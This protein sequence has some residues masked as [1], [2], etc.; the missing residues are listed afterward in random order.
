[1][2]RRLHPQSNH[3][4]SILY[5][6]LDDWRRTEM[7]KIKANTAAGDERN[8]AMANLLAEE[9]K[10]LQNIQ[11]LKLVASKNI[12]SSKTE[13]MLDLMAKP[14]KW[15]LSGGDVALVQTP[16][17]RRAKEL[18]D[19]YEALNKP[20]GS[21]PIDTRLDVLLHVKW[22]VLEFNTPLTKDIADLADREGDLLSRGRPVKSMDRLRTR[23]ANL[24]LEFLETPKYNPRAADF[25]G[26][27]AG[28]GGGTEA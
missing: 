20:V 17:T 3:D 9:T 2:N 16:A 27:V 18:L 28:G 23:L 4:F 1:M 5:S 21:A 6:E 10:A 8:A 19:L 7:A 15:Q 13:Q 25:V 11:K 22:T 24:F 26:R 12:H 14:H